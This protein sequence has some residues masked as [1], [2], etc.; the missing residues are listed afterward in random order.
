MLVSSI[1][2]SSKR[3]NKCLYVANKCLYVGSMCDF[4]ASFST[5]NVE[6]V[7][8][9]LSSLLLYVGDSTSQLCF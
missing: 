3:T 5:S 9:L 2:F 7:A 1:C 4:S 8:P 6:H